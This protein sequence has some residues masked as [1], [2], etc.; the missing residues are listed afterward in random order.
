MDLEGGGWARY[1]LS[2]QGAVWN[3][4]DQ[5]Q[6]EIT[7]EI[8]SSSDV[9]QMID[10]KY[11][12]FLVKTDVVFKLQGDDSVNP[13]RLTT[14]TI[15]WLEETAVYVNAYANDHTRLEFVTGSGKNL[16]LFLFI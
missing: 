15:P 8:I 3:F 13:S 2:G 11:N 14:R 9:K 1:G 4:V 5:D 7:L 12:R 16:R 6:T 10:L